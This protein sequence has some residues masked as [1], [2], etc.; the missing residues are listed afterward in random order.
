MRIGILTSGGD[1]PGLNAVLR[2]AVLQASS[3]GATEIVGLL[4]GWRG[5]VARASRPLSLADVVGIH[6]RGGTIL[7]ASRTNPL[8]AD[9][10]TRGVRE[11]MA[12]LRLDGL[13]AV[14]GE[15][16]L[17]VAEILRRDGV[18]VVGVPK[19]IDNDIAGT[20]YSFG[21]DTAVSIAT[22]AIDRIGTTAEAH[23]RC[24]V[25]EVMGRQVGWIALNAGIA[26]GAHTVLIPE[27]AVSIDEICGA[28]LDVRDSGHAPIVV[29]AEGFRLAGQ[30]RAHSHR[31]LDA[32]DRPRLGG[33]G[34][35]L[36]PMIEER[37][38]IESRS[39]ALGYIQRGGA[40]TSY[41]RVLA[42]RLGMAAA[43][44]A[45]EG[46]FGTMSSLRGTE[47]IDVPLESATATLNGVPSAR[48]R[49][50]TALFA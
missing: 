35:V 49:E 45:I 13:I 31:G 7:G 8:D 32:F 44:A 33:I 12:E 41:D 3:G 30:E 22:E 18:N 34:E 19:T 46:R 28:A 1:C 43:S 14:G 5:L 42:T 36:A 20:D 9:G 25:V 11:A 16:T 4:G 10:G 48:Y 29:V 2:G 17:S 39:T 26:S 47:I 37:T 6:A 38:G 40:P 27:H 21:F 50:A 23:D 24:I 15:G